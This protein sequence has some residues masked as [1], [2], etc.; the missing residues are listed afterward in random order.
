MAGFGFMGSTK[1]TKLTAKIMEDPVYK[2]M[3][4]E[5]GYPGN[6][7]AKLY[8]ITK[9]EYKN[10]QAGELDELQGLNDDYG[11]GL[12]SFGNQLDAK[13][14]ELIEKG[15]DPDSNK[16]YINLKNEYTDSKV[17][18]ENTNSYLNNLKEESLKS[19]SK[20]ERALFETESQLKD[21]DGN[22]VEL[23][24]E[25]HEVN[26]V[27]FGYEKYRD[28]SEDGGE[29]YQKI[30][31]KEAKRQLAAINGVSFA[32]KRPNYDYDIRI[33]RAKESRDK[34]IQ[35]NLDATNMATP[36]SKV[37]IPSGSKFSSAR[38]QAYTE[39]NEEN[40]DIRTVSISGEKNLTLAD[41]METDEFVK[42][43]GE[44]TF[45]IKK[46][47]TVDGYNNKGALFNELIIRSKTDPKK[48]VTVQID[49]SGDRTIMRELY[50]DLASSSD[51]KQSLE[52]EKGLANLMYMPSI[53][54][55]F[56]R[57]STKG[58]LNIQ[59]PDETRTDEVTFSKNED[60]TYAGTLFGQVIEFNGNAD[61]KSEQEFAVA[62]KRE[63][64]DYMI[65]KKNA[66]EKAALK[67]KK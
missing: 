30:I 45:E 66:E 8:K 63:V 5:N 11:I 55:A 43:M 18:F 34:H 51:Q 9:G 67:L 52:G 46:S 2:K 40:M 39:M 4:L 25:E 37:Q 27:S 20:D 54:Q 42:I 36:Y 16:E 62:L 22:A 15:E 48:S 35:N 31:Q 58:S 13:R 50:Q 32:S 21:F 49:A 1:T 19:L 29:R 56:L 38:F 6:K 41:Y 59:L 12:K 60:G 10:L 24:M 53:K 33:N 7:A 17:G 44:D 26:P 64:E 47:F 3:L 28:G 65:A 57:Y 23:M 61:L 14:K